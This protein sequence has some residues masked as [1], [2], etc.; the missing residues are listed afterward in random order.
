VDTAKGKEKRREKR[1]RREVYNVSI[2]AKQI[3]NLTK[4]Y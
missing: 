4:S 2:T 3:I 1:R